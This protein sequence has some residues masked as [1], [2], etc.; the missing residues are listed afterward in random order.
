MTKLYPNGMWKFYFLQ[1][2]LFLGNAWL[3]NLKCKYCKCYSLCANERSR[4]TNATCLLSTPGNPHLF[5]CRIMLCTKS[6]WMVVTMY[7][8]IHQ[9]EML[10]LRAGMDFVLYS[11]VSLN[12]SVFLTAEEVMGTRCLFSSGFCFID[13]LSD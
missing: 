4:S 13:V 8:H 7:V 1:N 10:H 9:P 5:V 11:T 6:V 2:C 3:F 12:I